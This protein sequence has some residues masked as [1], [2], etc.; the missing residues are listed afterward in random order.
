MRIVG[1]EDRAGFEGLS[2]DPDV[3][4]RDGLARLLQS[5]LDQSEV[6][7]GFARRVEDLRQP[8]WSGRPFEKLPVRLFPSTPSGIPRGAP[9][10]QKRACRRGRLW[11]GLFKTILVAEPGNQ[12]ISIRVEQDGSHC[13][14]FSSA[15]LEVSDRGSRFGSFGR[16]GPNA[17]RSSNLCPI[18]GRLVVQTQGLGDQFFHDL[19]D[20][21]PL[22]FRSLLD[23]F[24]RLLVD[25]MNA[26]GI[27]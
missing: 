9:P 25:P 13:Q 4:E 16:E 24:F 19:I 11:P 7:G 3:V 14:S 26:D 21:L 18:I 17:A 22:V 2:G 27:S 5:R 23:G 15:D 12:D 6:L 20:A 1:H 8:A 10:E